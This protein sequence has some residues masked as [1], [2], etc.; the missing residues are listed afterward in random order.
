VVEAVSN[1]NPVFTVKEI[2]D[3]VKFRSKSENVLVFLAISIIYKDYPNVVGTTGCPDASLGLIV[4]LSVSKSPTNAI[5]LC[6]KKN[7]EVFTC[8]SEG[9]IVLNP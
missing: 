5:G 1:P 8:C 2:G 6:S 4:S 7:V 9:F 3:G